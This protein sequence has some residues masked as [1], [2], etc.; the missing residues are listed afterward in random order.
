MLQRDLDVVFS[1]AE[2]NVM[3]FIEVKFERMSHGKAGDI[4]EG[5]FRTRS[6]K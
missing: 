5:K 4:E 2:E 3:E 1:W 6:R